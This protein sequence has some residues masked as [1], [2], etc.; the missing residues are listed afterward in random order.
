[1]IDSNFIG[2]YDY[3]FH[4]ND[5]PS[6]GFSPLVAAASQLNVT[7]TVFSGNMHRFGGAIY[8]NRNTPSGSIDATITNCQIIQNKAAFGG[9]LY[10]STRL[11][12][13]DLYILDSNFT[14]NTVVKSI[15][16]T[17]DGG[18]L[19]FALSFAT[20]IN[21]TLMRNYFIENEVE[22]DGGVLIYNSGSPSG[23]FYVRN[24]TFQGNKAINAGVFYLGQL[25][26]YTGINNTYIANLA[27]ENG[28]YFLKS[29][30]N[31]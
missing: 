22:N 9:A 4:S 25:L 19:A 14:Q 29:F 30:V 28:F 15:G 18:C 21:V 20:R 31:L 26:D 10:T 17:A 6:K 24:N 23:S 7:R 12:V 11:N 2:N 27:E 13:L 1:M 16:S 3:Y 5:E 8:L